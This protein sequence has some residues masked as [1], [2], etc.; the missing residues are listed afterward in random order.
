MIA[1]EHLSTCMIDM[2][3]VYLP[4]CY[5]TLLH[6]WCGVGCHCQE[7]DLALHII[8]ITR[9][10]HGGLVCADCD[11]MEEGE[12]GGGGELKRLLPAFVIE[13]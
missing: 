9:W 2:V 12:R 4:M 5:C 1:A 11:N 8:C 13:S 6:T 7:V 10:Q 3:Y